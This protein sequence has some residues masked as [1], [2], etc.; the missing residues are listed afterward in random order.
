MKKIE[1]DE[2]GIIRCKQEIQSFKNYKNLNKYNGKQHIYI[3][4]NP[5]YNLKSFRLTK[6]GVNAE[7]LE[8]ISII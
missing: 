2:G 1:N 4:F 6:D 3:I 7:I 5:K 8:K